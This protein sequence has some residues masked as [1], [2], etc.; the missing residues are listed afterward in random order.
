MTEDTCWTN[1]P[2]MSLP[3]I[4]FQITCVQ[5]VHTHVSWEKEAEAGGE[6]FPGLKMCSPKPGKATT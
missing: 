6:G 5:E 1:L 3:A 4:E 2:L